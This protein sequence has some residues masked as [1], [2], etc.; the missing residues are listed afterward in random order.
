MDGNLAGRAHELFKEELQLKQEEVRNAR[1]AVWV[2][3][4]SAIATAA[5]VVVAAV[6]AAFAARAVSV[7]EMAIDNQTKEARFSTAVQA[8]GA[9]EPAE[10]VAGAIM[11]RRNVEDRLRSARDENDR[12]DAF[13]LYVTTENI[14]ENYLKAPVES[15]PSPTLPGLPT[16]MAAGRNQSATS[17]EPDARSRAAHPASEH[18]YVAGQLAKLLAKKNGGMLPG[19]VNNQWV[20]IDLANVK[21]AGQHWPRVDFSWLDGKYFYGIDLHKANLTNSSWG[22]ATLTSASLQC[23]NLAGA[24]F[25]LEKD[26]KLI[27]AHLEKAKLRHA[28]LQNADLRSTHLEGADLTGAYIHGTR[29][30]PD[31]LQGATT[32]GVIVENKEFVINNECIENR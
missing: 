15:P 10:R 4:I 18:T 11:L 29:F 20:S 32:D 9:D 28:N 22:N 24:K 21:L 26:G 19:L 27:G 8:L 25:N 23:A 31:G 7:A 14:I 3:A 16:V 12:Q 5:A 17:S 2:G 30:D 6:T 1:R 13:N